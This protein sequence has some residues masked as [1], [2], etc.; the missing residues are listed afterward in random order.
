MRKRAP[1]CLVV[2]FGLLFGLAACAGEGQVV[3]ILEERVEELEEEVAELQLFVGLEVKEEPQHEQA[4]PQK[5][6]QEKT[7]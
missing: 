3:E 1:V 4:Q 7:Q 2:F 6:Q 5:T